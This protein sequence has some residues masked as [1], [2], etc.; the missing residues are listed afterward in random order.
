MQEDE[1]FTIDKS[2]SDDQHL[3]V[4]VAGRGTVIIHATDEGIVVDIYPFHVAAESVA[5][6]WAGMCDLIE[7]EIL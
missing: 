2:A 4:D 3:C 1:M 7:P 5:S 6:C